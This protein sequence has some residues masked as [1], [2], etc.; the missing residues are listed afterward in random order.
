[1]TEDKKYIMQLITFQK[2]VAEIVQ[3]EVGEVLSGRKDNAYTIACQI[4]Y[5]L[6]DIFNER[7]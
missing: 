1:M 3:T 4:D 5:L 7:D 6:A 2:R